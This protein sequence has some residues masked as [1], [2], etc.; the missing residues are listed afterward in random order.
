M[1]FIQ[2]EEQNRIVNLAKVRLLP[3]V[4]YVG[5]V[6]QVD[7]SDKVEFI[8]IQSIL[9]VNNFVVVNEQKYVCPSPNRYDRD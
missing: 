5:C 1:F 2:S 3:K 6:W 7:V 9:N 4:Q 8:P